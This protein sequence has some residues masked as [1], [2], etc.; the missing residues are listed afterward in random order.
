VFASFAKQAPITAKLVVGAD[1]ANS[2]L[3][4][5]LA[6]PISFRDYDHHAL[7]ANIHCP[8]GHRNTA[9]QVFL[10]EGPLAF[11]PTSDANVCSIVWSMSP[12]SA[13]AKVNEAEQAFNKALTAATDG[14]FGAVTLQSARASFPLT[15]RLAHDFFQARVALIGDAAHTI[16]PLAGQ[17]VNLGFLDAAALV[18][19]IVA[20]VVAHKDIANYPSLAQFSRWRKAHASEMV[21]AMEAIKQS[22]TPQQGIAKLVRGV[23][24]TLINNVKPIKNLLVKQALGE[25]DDLP[26]LAKY[27]DPL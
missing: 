1:G 26:S 21:V 4:Q 23:G 16:H 24:M 12:E 17:G 13:I 11:L 2:W 10:P 8:Q 18:D 9:W 22:F 6:M 7:V 20:N 5:Q 25:R 14:K 3:R 27:H 19:I 15:M